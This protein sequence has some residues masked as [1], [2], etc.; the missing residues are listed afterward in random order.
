MCVWLTVAAHA[1]KG[2]VERRRSFCKWKE[3]ERKYGGR[4]NSGLGILK[5]PPAEGREEE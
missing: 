5:K 4:S 2:G 3:G 1:L